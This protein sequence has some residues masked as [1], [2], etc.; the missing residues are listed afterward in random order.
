MQIILFTSDGRWIVRVKT[1]QV[2]EMKALASVF[3]FIE[4]KLVGVILTAEERWENVK[5]VQWQKVGISSSRPCLGE[6]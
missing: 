5:V 6:G 2:A 4:A 3:H 1:E